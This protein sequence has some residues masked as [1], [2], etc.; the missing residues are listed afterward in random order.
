MK[1]VDNYTVENEGKFTVI[2]SPAHP[3]VSSFVYT[4]VTKMGKRGVNSKPGKTRPDK[5]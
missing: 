4:Y 1:T 3:R 2:A 5:L